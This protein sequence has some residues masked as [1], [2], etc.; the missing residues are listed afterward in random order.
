MVFSIPDYLFAYHFSLV[1]SCLIS[2]IAMEE[3][4]IDRP[5]VGGFDDSRD[6]RSRYSDDPL[7]LQNSNHPGMTL[8]SSVLVGNN[9]VAW[10]RSIKIALGVKLNLI[11][12]M[13]NVSVRL[14]FT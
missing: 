13:V 12:S 10:S 11:S 7:F 3:E 2:L 14:K 9:Y 6:T 4:H 8:V 1:V 5:S